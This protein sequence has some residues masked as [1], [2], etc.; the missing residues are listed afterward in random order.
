V[1]IQVLLLPYDSGRRCWRMG[2]GPEHLLRHGAAS[3]LRA[4][5]H[6]VTAEYVEHDGDHASDV[7]AS[8]ALYRRLARRV[9]EAA[10]AG[11]LPIVL[12]GNCGATL[13]AMSG[14]GPET[15]LLWLD[16][17][18]D[19][20][21]PETSPSGFLDGM[22]LATLTGRCWQSVAATIPGWSPLPEGLVVHGAGRDFDDAELAHMRVSEMQVVT[23][24]AIRSEGVSSAFA[25]ALDQLATR[26]RR[27]HLHV[28]LDSLDAMRVGKANHFATEGGLS[29]EELGEI[30]RAARSRFT[31][32][33]AS[34]SAYDP[35]HDESGGVYRAALAA[36]EQLAPST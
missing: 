15:G 32:T 20:N 35:E 11:Q 22:A 25:P 3:T 18:G 8:F 33:S 9:R 27:L 6:E 19:F 5:G 7:D 13:G 1:K 17:H 31:L 30:V 10:S 34:V 16:A 14:I 12:S 28:D 29:H 36:L 26:T 2:N 4:L 21:T 23:A 24:D